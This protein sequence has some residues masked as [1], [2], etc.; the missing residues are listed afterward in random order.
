MR[1]GCHLL[2][3]FGRI[4]VSSRRNA[5]AIP[6]VWFRRGETHEPKGRKQ[7]K[8]GTP[9]NKG[10]IENMITLPGWANHDGRDRFY[11]LPA[12]FPASYKYGKNIGV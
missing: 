3:D 4:G 12:R 1:E 7:R 2:A 8:R 11:C 5:C 10:K 6:N 9:T